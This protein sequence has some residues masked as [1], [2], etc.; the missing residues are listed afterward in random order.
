MEPPIDNRPLT[1]EE[2]EDRGASSTPVNRLANE[3]MPPVP[4]LLVVLLSGVAGVEFAADDGN[5]WE[6]EAGRDERFT[7]PDERAARLSVGRSRVCCCWVCEVV[8]ERGAAS[9]TVDL[10]LPLVMLKLLLLLAVGSSAK[11]ES[12]S[13]EVEEDVGC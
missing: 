2:V 10:T 12:L 13:D 6:G 11:E 8:A 3:D 7:L 5:E 1:D 9:A 4:L